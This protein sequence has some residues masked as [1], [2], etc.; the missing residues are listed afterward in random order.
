MSWRSKMQAASFRGAAFHVRG[1]RANFGRRQV[2]HEYPLRELPYVEDL[3]RKARHFSFEAFVIGPDYMADRDALI[4]ACEAEGAATLV[5]P[6]LGSM[7]VTCERCGEEE[8]VEAG[9]FARFSL[10]FLEAGEARYPS[11]ATSYTNQAGQAA[12]SLQESAASV[13]SQ[14][15][16]AVGPAWLAAA[17]AGDVKTALALARAVVTAIP[18]PFDQEEVTAFLD[19]LDQAAAAADVATSADGATLAELITQAIT[20]LGDLASDGQETAAVDAALEIT[21]FGASAGDSGAS[22]YGGTLEEVPTTTATRA[23]QATNRD[24]IVALVQDLAVSEGVKAALEGDYASY[25]EAA[26]VRDSLL[27]RIDDLMLGAGSDPNPTSD[28]RYEA[29]RSLYASTRSAFVELGADLAREV[30]LTT[31]GGLTP[32]LVV[33]YDRYGELGR[34]EEI[35]RRNNLRHPGALPPATTLQVLNV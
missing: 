9:G 32:S 4:A 18:S 7:Q 19:A 34:A 14:I 26:T 33:A 21:K 6:Y 8:N 12:S 15:Y 5:H 20:G 1:H 28:I 10:S 17:A 16:N 25:Q 2:V 24:A 27:E 11:Q 13:F 23:T 29:L 35:V 31:G 3:G 30:P 22:I